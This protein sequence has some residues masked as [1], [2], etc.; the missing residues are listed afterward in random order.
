M[1]KQAIF[2]TSFVS[3]EGYNLFPNIVGAGFNGDYSFISTLRALLA[4]RIGNDNIRLV[5]D[6]CNDHQGFQD[7]TDPSYL[8]RDICCRVTALNDDNSNTIS[9]VNL[10]AN[11]EI[12]RVCLDTI[13]EYLPKCYN[14]WS[15]IQKVTEFY[16]KSFYV[17]CFINMERKNVAL[18]V[19]NMDMRK[20]HYLQCSIFAF[21]PWYFDP[22]DGLS[23]IEMELV[24]SLR[25]KT[26]EKY[27]ETI[28]KIAKKYD[29]RTEHIRRLLG[30]FETIY[31]QNE[32]KNTCKKIEEYLSEI[33]SLNNRIGTFLKMK[34]EM[35][36]RMLGLSAKIEQNNGDSEI[37]EYFLCNK[38]L[39][40]E[41]VSEDGDL[42]FS[43]KDYLTYFDDEI[44]KRMIDN[45]RSCIYNPRGRNGGK[46]IQ[47]DDM[48][49]L[50]Y[51]IFIDQTLKIK[52]CASYSFNL[53]ANIR[54][55]KYHHYGIGFRDCMPNPHI[56]RYACLGNNEHAI[57]QLLANH[58]Y[59]TAIEQA[60]S[61]CKSLN[62]ADGAVMEE[63]MCRIYGIDD[64]NVNNRCI[65]LP[66]GSVVTPV[67]AIAWL[68]TRKGVDGNE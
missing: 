31:E 66:D 48:K 39:V 36:V 32:L 61:S 13:M 7:S 52:F 11:G 23:P 18:F 51:A 62:F 27:E 38:K 50:M 60:I 4:P 47:P 10:T 25:E 21:L 17:L 53:R 28:E 3:E 56:D 54:G 35:E 44:A 1:F 15:L 33:E 46:I 20:M 30:G 43:C 29:M 5:F 64:N 42:D 14:G 65:E 6:S 24:N 68:Q 2:D 9:V 19:D 22:K 37:M 12:N 55:K 49:E 34:S 16:R 26:P 63:F 41:N 40:L 67:V 57:N 58:D 59:I 45:P 8:T